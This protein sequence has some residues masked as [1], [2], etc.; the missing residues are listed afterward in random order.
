MHRHPTPLESSDSQAK[1]VVFVNKQDR[2][3]RDFGLFPA[4]MAQSRNYAAGRGP[5]DQQI[6]GQGCMARGV[7]GVSSTGLKLLEPCAIAGAA[8]HPG[9]GGA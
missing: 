8:R 6:E 3:S 1:T 7:G 4:K 5:G 9:P 2:S